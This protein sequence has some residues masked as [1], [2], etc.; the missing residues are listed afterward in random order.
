MNH[1]QILLKEKEQRKREL[2]N[3]EVF[4]KTSFDFENHLLTLA[5]SNGYTCHVL[6]KTYQKEINQHQTIL[7]LEL[8]YKS[9]IVDVNKAMVA[10]FPQNQRGYGDPK[11]WI[12]KKIPYKEGLEVCDKSYTSLGWQKNLTNTLCFKMWPSILEVNFD[13]QGNRREALVRARM[14]DFRRQEIRENQANNILASTMKET[15]KKVV[16]CHQRNMIKDCLHIRRDRRSLLNYVGL[17]AKTLADYFKY[18]EFRCLNSKPSLQS[19][20]DLI[21]I[22]LL[23]YAPYNLPFKKLQFIKLENIDRVT[24]TITI[25]EISFPIPLNF[26]KLAKTVMTKDETLLQRDVHQLNKFVEQT[27]KAAGLKQ[28][29]PKLIRRSLTFICHHANIMIEHLPRR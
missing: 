1:R 20:K 28:I 26:I 13:K 21:A 4:L 19:Y 12:E 10:S 7:D 5:G 29:N 9:D 3:Y 16:L 6:P 8:P 17:S 22:R 27:S 23:F 18:L 14:E 25:E 24:N 11:K 15:S 2:E